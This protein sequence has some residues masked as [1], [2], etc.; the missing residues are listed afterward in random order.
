VSSSK[1]TEQI[2]VSESDHS[3]T[4]RRQSCYSLPA[5]KLP[6]VRAVLSPRVDL[7]RK[8]E[9]EEKDEQF[10]FE[11][12]S[13]AESAVRVQIQGAWVAKPPMG[14]VRHEGRSEN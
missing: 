3:V 5:D 6:E 13:G 9:G 11:G 10:W 1:G 8:L 14:G 12:G 7:Q 4:S 2:E